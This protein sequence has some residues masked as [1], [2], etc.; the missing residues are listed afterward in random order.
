M[1]HGGKRLSK[2]VFLVD[3]L[4][5]MNPAMFVSSEDDNE[6]IIGKRQMGIDMERIQRMVPES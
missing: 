1:F 3:V 6:T 4:I 5:Y 2:G